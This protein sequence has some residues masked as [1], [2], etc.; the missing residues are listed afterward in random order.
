MKEQTTINQIIPLRSGKNETRRERGLSYLEVF[1][2]WL[3]FVLLIVIVAVFL[4]FSP[5]TLT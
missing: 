3:F 4:T 1:L 5:F 2:T